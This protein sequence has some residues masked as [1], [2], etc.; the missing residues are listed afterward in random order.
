MNYTEKLE[1][2]VAALEAQ[3]QKLESKLP[4]RTYKY[5]CVFRYALDKSTYTAH[6]WRNCQHW[7]KEAGDTVEVVIV[8][9]P[10]L[11]SALRKAIALQ[12]G[13]N[14]YVECLVAVGGNKY[15]HGDIWGKFYYRPAKGYRQTNPKRF[16][17]EQRNYEYV[18]F[19]LRK[20][21]TKQSA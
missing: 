20:R 17:Y 13:Y 8:D 4:K 21:S 5:T 11:R 10:S 2:K 6:Q 19:P 1:V 14:D 12:K 15:L 7:G 18:R 16:W 9:A 3:I